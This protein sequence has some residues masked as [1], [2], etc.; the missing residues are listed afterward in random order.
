M[1]WR[2]QLGTEP[3]IYDDTIAFYLWESW[4]GRD[5]NGDGDM[6]DPILGIHQIIDT[7]MSMVNLETWLF[8][9]I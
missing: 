9:V 4:V 5:L 7:Q 1:R 3:D 8:L 6:S 2:C